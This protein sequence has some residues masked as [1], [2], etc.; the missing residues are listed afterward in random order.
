MSTPNDSKLAE[1]Y[2]D[3]QQAQARLQMAQQ[4]LLGAQSDALAKEA[5]FKGAAELVHGKDATFEF[6][7]GKLTFLPPALAGKQAATHGPG[8]RKKK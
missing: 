8:K 5:R 1:M 6:K 2:R 7:D 4:T 3:W